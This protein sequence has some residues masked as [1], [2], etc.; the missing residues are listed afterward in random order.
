M[1]PGDLRYEVILMVQG[2]VQFRE[3]GKHLMIY[4]SERFLLLPEQKRNSVKNMFYLVYYFVRKNEGEALKLL[5]SS[6]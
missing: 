4:I 3:K 5:K 1:L 2:D 6:R